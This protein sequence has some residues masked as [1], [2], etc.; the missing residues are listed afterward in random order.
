MSIVLSKSLLL[1]SRFSFRS[2]QHIVKYLIV[3]TYYSGTGNVP[4]PF[5]TKELNNNKIKE[6]GNNQKDILFNLGNQFIYVISYIFGLCLHPIFNKGKY[7]TIIK[8]LIFYPI[9]INTIEHNNN[10]IGA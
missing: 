1:S 6:G 2:F 7:F 10:K 5:S 4:A 3:I 9:E 8:F